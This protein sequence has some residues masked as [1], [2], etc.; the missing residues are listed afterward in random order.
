MLK[1]K[2]LAKLSKGD[3]EALVEALAA[4]LGGPDASHRVGSPSVARSRAK[5][6][7]ARRIQFLNS[8]E[9]EALFAAIR[10][11]GNERDLALFE[12][13]YHR[14][15]RAS[16][17]GMLKTGHLR[18]AQRRIYVTRLKKSK[19]G[20]YPL[21]ERE[22]RAL[23]VWMRKR[24]QVAGAIF[25]SRNRKPISRRR[26]DQ[27]MKHYGAVANLPD[28]KRHFHCLRHTCATQLVERDVDLLLIGDHLG[29]CD[30]RNTQV[31]A[32]VSDRKR[33]TLAERLGDF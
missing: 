16:E 14:G 13:A 15:L 9:L 31:Y 2:D 10:A 1:T 17:V 28:E 12:V 30:I 3:L 5:R 29:H 11:G 4:R 22:V 21:T 26:L 32:K 18:L 19:S 6:N 23:R 33:Q 7:S 25:L 20:E 27:L 8:E 24:G